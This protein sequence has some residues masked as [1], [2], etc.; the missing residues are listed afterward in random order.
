M[1][2]FLQNLR[3]RHCHF[4]GCGGAGMFCLCII[5]E[6]L[7]AIVSGSDI[8]ESKNTEHLKKLGIP[9]QLEHS[10]QNIPLA[11]PAHPLPL[12]I[13]SSAI[14]DANPELEAA[15]KAGMN[16]ML[17]GEFL[18]LFAKSC[19]RTV[20]VAGSHGK[21]TVTSMISH[22]AR[23]C[24]LNPGYMIGG[25]VAS[26][27]SPASAGNGDIFVTEADESDG[28]LVHLQ[29]YLGIITN[30]DDDHSWAH[31]GIERIHANFAKFASNSKTAIYG[32]S[33]LANNEHQL[34][35]QA[36]TV[37]PEC[38]ASLRENRKFRGFQM[39][40]A[41]I[42]LDALCELGSPLR[43]AL[44]ALE[45]FPGVERRMSVRFD[46]GSM[47]L[48]E[49]YAHHPTEISASIDFLKEE[50]PGRRTVIVFQPHRQARLEKY[51]KELACELRKAD[52]VFI[53]PVFAAW[54]ERGRPDS[55]D[56]AA[57]LGKSAEFCDLPW[58]T[59]SDMILSFANSGDLIAVIGAGD[60]DMLVPYLRDGM[61]KLSSNIS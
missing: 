59:L 15:K 10:P 4:I 56:L 52:K 8:I 38:I 11:E 53:V 28:T 25:K 43:E 22:A 57:E 42:S 29:P 49:D 61:R 54:G 23:R 27:E 7:G 30:I 47:T 46:N 12:V 39:K 5:A 1:K 17:R 26:W 60:I 14:S 44:D 36:R 58:E 3:G 31:G 55:A 45:S 6:E 41:A 9:V 2:N 40:N 13:R 37:S 19:R 32:E 24:G 16:P 21:T 50:Y 20:A 18:A 33:E 48:I 35:L 34:A 51:F